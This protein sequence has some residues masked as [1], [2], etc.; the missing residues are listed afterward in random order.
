[1]PEVA[2]KPEGQ[3]RRQSRGRPKGP[4][5]RLIWVRTRAQPDRHP[6]QAAEE[7]HPSPTPH[8]GSPSFTPCRAQ[9]G[10][11]R[12]RSS[13]HP[14]L[15][16]HPTDHSAGIG[17]PGASGCRPCRALTVRNKCCPRSPAPDRRS[18]HCRQRTEV[19]V[20]AVFKTGD[21][22]AGQAVVAIRGHAPVP[23]VSE[24]ESPV[25]HP[26]WKCYLAVSYACPDGPGRS[27]FTLARTGWCNALRS[28][29]RRFE[30]CRGRWSEALIRTLG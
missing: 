11:A 25:R 4:Q 10:T 6:Q 27:T 13:V 2:P 23:L 28:R 1:M 20:P 26:R 30:S 22:G 29:E 9:R 15:L 24:Q 16:E 19:T 12:T 21:V 17:R 5:D 7:S 8:G 18:Q 3:R 14:S